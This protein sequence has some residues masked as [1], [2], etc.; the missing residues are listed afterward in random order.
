MEAGLMS[1]SNRPTIPSSVSPIALAASRMWSRRPARVTEAWVA[2]LSAVPV[3]PGARMASPELP[4]GSGVGVPKISMAIPCLFLQGQIGVS[5]KHVG[6][7]GGRIRIRI[8]V[9]PELPQRL[10]DR[11]V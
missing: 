11:N 6:Q 5:V 4:T 2:M 3:L 8:A 7:G 9:G 10:A 1:I